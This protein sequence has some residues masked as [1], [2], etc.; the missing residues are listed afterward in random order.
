MDTANIRHA[1]SAA[2]DDQGVINQYNASQ[3]ANSFS[4]GDWRQAAEMFAP[5]PGQQNGFSITDDANGTVIIHNDMTEA[6]QIANSTVP[7]IMMADAKGVLELA[8]GLEG[9]FTVQA[10]ISGGSV[11]LGE[12]TAF[13]GVAVA[14]GAAMLP[15]ALIGGAIALAAVAG[16]PL[17]WASQKQAEARSELLT[18]Q[19]VTIPQQ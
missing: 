9:A 16:G 18:A 17:M 8:A 3:L 10:A 1:I 4:P 13:G 6:R 11:A 15:A 5:K 14:A 19:T 12:G 7:Q 2:H